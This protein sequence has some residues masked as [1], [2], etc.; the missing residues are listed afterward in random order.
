MLGNILLGEGFN[1]S[2][3]LL[4]EVNLTENI[5]KGIPIKFILGQGNLPNGLT[6]KLT[7][8][9]EN[10]KPIKDSS[11]NEIKDVTLTQYNSTEFTGVYYQDITIHADTPD[12]YIRLYY[13]CSQYNILNTYQPQDAKLV[14]SSLKDAE[15]V[16]VQ[17]FID[18]ILAPEINIDPLYRKAI[19]DY[20]KRNREGVRKY[21][22]GAESQL[23]R[24]TRLYFAER[25]I[26]DEKKDYFFDQFNIHLWQFEVA[27]PPINELVD[28]K[29][30]YG[31]KE[32]A[33]IDTKFFVFDRVQGLIE[34]LP[35]P[36]GDSAGIYSM[37][38]GGVA[39]GGSPFL[40]LTSN[41]L[42]RI[43]ALFR[44]TYKTGLI[45]DGCDV[46]EKESIRMAICNRA[47]INMLPKIDPALR[48]GSYSEGAD[49]VSSN[50]NYMVRDILKGYEE[51]EK[52]FI[53][54]L[55]TKYGR[56]LDVVVV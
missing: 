12:Q 26:T 43:P 6:I 29:I 14:G 51:Q 52:E 40:F 30:V 36:T 47:L 5:V 17:Y 50:R 35:S 46:K 53:E 3:P 10:G 42:S 48:S 39:M 55:R 7:I 41:N 27:Y 22:Q 28:F 21:L 8:I 44:A 31:Q 16:P 24:A 19:G 1:Q 38:L 23:E 34:F 4:S 56:N 9:G 32:I 11:N 45:Y 25:T 37:V 13:T 20:V 33:K 49:G 54:D 15:V 2:V 18:Y